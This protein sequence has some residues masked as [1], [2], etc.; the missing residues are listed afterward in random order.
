MNIKRWYKWH[1]HTPIRHFFGLKAKTDWIDAYTF[2]AKKMLPY[3]Y[4]FRDNEKH[5]TPCF[6]EIKDMSSFSDEQIK[7]LDDIRIFEWDR[8]IDEIIFALEYC[9]D[10][11]DDDCKVPNPLYNPNQKKWL[12]DTKPNE[13]GLSVMEFNDDYGETKTDMNLLREKME[14]V[15]EGLRLMGEYFMNIWD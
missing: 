8:I 1:I 10:E 15:K 12:K 9:V 5:G 11:N 7:T 2:M 14:R 13:K 3:L 6:D 4:D